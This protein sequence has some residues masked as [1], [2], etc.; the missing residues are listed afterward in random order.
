MDWTYPPEAEA[1]RAEL[2][3][4]LD[5]ALEPRFAALAGVSTH[6]EEQLAIHREW[7]QRVAEAGYAAIAWP[8]EYGGRGAGLLEQVVLAEEFDRAGAPMHLNTLGL[9]N[10]APA[11]L[12]F[13]T[14]EQK[15]THLPPMASGE[16]V[17]CQGFSEPDAGSD[18]ASLRTRAVRD[19]G[20]WVVTG[21]KVWTSFG[22][23]ADR[24]ELLVRTDADAP[25]HRGIT[26][27]L[28]DLTS[29][30]VQVRPLVTITGEAEFNEVVLDEVRVPISDTL[31][32]VNEGWTVA[33]TTLAHERMGVVSLHLQVRRRIRELA[34]LAAGRIIDE[35][36][37]VA[38]AGV[39]RELAR[40]HR[41][42][43]LLKLLADRTLSAAVRGAE[44]GAASSVA[45]LHWSELEQRMQEVAAAL[46]GTDADTEPWRTERLRARGY[47]IAGGTTQVNKNILAQRILGLPRG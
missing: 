36:P 8:D 15:R 26:C 41:D 14:E 45:K 11:I 9:S 35:R 32:P 23:Y 22:R 43:E 29:P 46:L 20:E 12:A 13:G 5:E 28:L 42:G 47:T 10:I 16:R 34:T 31:G 17:W 21:R 1:F 19:G 37:A 18:L 2:A 25:K 6:D 27:L 7:Q 44:P 40:L 3:A 33:M 4:W 30:G 38:D 39:R 24:C